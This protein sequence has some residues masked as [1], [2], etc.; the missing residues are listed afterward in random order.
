MYQNVDI[1]ID[2][3]VKVWTF[4]VVIN[5]FYILYK[6]N[7]SNINVSDKLSN[8]IKSDFEIIIMKGNLNIKAQ[9]KY[10]E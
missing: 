4:K 2:R 9:F 8:N 10:N 5:R 7:K 1:L 6:I 3:N